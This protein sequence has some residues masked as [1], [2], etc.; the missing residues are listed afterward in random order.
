MDKKLDT[1]FKNIKE[2]SIPI[3]YNHQC[4]II[5]EKISSHPKAVSYRNLFQIKNLAYSA[6]AAL[7]IIISLSTI[8]IISI[9]KDSSID[10]FLASTFYLD[11]QENDENDKDINFLLNEGTFL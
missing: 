11:M 1:I 8:N 7:I 4:E 2:T 3:D 9:S 5:M 6:L 10:N